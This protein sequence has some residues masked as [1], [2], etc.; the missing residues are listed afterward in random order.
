MYMEQMKKSESVTDL[1]I[2]DKRLR[3]WVF[4]FL[5][6]QRARDK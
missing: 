5:E 1:I 3:D 2:S 6:L 4:F